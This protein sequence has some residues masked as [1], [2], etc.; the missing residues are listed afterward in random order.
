[1]K[2]VEQNR[3]ALKTG[4]RMNERVHGNYENVCS[5]F[6]EYTRRLI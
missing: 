4:T 3:I 2:Y 6:Y 1:M 5:M